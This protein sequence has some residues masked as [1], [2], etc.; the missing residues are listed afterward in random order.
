MIGFCGLK[1][2]GK[3]T[4]YQI[5][6]SFDDR[7]QKISFAD[8]LKDIVSILF[9]WPREDLEGQGENRFWRELPDEYWSEKLGED[10]SPRRAL[11]VIGTDV[12]RNHLHK[13]IWVLVAER[14][15]YDMKEQGKIPVVTDIR[16]PNEFE[17]FKNMGEIWEVQREIPNWYW[18]A[19][20]YN[21][22]PTGDMPLRLKEIHP[23]ERE[24]IGLPVSGI[25]NNTTTLKNLENQLRRLH[26]RMAGKNPG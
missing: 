20:D 14:K 6:K 21:L 2:S 19:K 8:A 1:G 13:N 24:W 11:Q 23:S 3:D 26:E 9:S 4:C 22:N 5:L 25:I 18:E 12:F 15:V 17:F 7:Y 10:W 16:F